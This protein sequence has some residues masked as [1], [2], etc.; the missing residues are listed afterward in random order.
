MLHTQMV[1]RFA[2]LSPISLSYGKKSMQDTQNRPDLSLFLASSAHDMKNSVSML[3]G[4]LES[5]LADTSEKLTPAYQ[6]MARML[7]ETRRLN[8]NLIQV[9]ALYKEVGSPSYP[10]DP[11]AQ[12]I[13]EFV[14]EVAARNHILL[15]SRGIV[16]D[17][18]YPA[19]LVWSFDEDL[20][21]GVVGHALNNAIH[22]T[23]DKIRLVIAQVGGFLEIRV[24]DNGVGYPP[25]MLAADAA[26]KAGVDFTTGS[27]GLGLYFSGEVAKMH[28]HRGRHGSVGLE[29]GGLWG[30]GCFVLRLP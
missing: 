26:V 20:V 4:T 5:L 12:A 6:Q 13:A 18:D 3:S 2:I 8:D 9:L 10:F 16:F 29:N 24:E 1:R 19:D 22:Y 14:E 25:A 21:I 28:K 17:T 27:T 30:G 7:Y 23:R 15:D 11:E